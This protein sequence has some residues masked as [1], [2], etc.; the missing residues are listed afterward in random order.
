MAVY[1]KLRR[2]SIE[3]IFSGYRL[4]IVFGFQ[5]ISQGIENTN[6]FVDTQ[7]QGENA[8][9]AT[10][11]WVLTIFENVVPK[12]I[13][14][15]CELTSHLNQ[16]GFDVPAPVLG[17]DGEYTFSYENK[18]G[19][20]VPRLK[21]RSLV[22]PALSECAKVSAWLANMHLSLAQF[23]KTRLAERDITWVKTHV[24]RLKEHMRAE[25]YSQLIYFSERYYRYHDDLLRCPQGTI[26]GDLFRDNVLFHDGSVSGVFDFYHACDSALIFDLAV[27]ANDWAFVNGKYDIK[28]L[29]SLVSS[30]QSIRPWTELE[31]KMWL[32]CLELA[33]LRFWISRLTSL[34]LPGY[35]QESVSGETLKDPGEMKAILT[36]LQELSLE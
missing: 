4:G 5:E 2:Q 23:S 34:Y 9:V 30:Y 8:H 28:K 21:G 16:E 36:H 7:K 22:F 17:S 25:E 24:G 10:Q 6:Y 33:A 29:N 19:L 18:V 20:I 35:Q 26:H 15:F 1:T 32:K 31:N 27:L 14:Y 11:Q 13:P 3:R 12:D